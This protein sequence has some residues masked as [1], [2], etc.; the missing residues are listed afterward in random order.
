MAYVAYSPKRTE[1][2]ARKENLSVLIG[3]LAVAGSLIFIALA[4]LG[5]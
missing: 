2:Q 1:S 3:R 4:I 5:L